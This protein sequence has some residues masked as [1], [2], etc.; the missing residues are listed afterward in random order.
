MVY[1][2]ILSQKSRTEESKVNTIERDFHISENSEAEKVSTQ[3]NM[4]MINKW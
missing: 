3:N 4:E 1:K 2:K